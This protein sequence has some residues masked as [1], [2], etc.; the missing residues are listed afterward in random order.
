MFL[1]P[2]SRQA[3]LLGFG[4]DHVMCYDEVKMA[5][6]ACGTLFPSFLPFIVNA[7]HGGAGESRGH[8]GRRGGGRSSGSALAAL[9]SAKKEGRPG[10]RSGRFGAGELRRVGSLR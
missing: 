3:Q 8:L 7:V 1:A 6:L 10:P 9:R 5:M 2:L 4:I